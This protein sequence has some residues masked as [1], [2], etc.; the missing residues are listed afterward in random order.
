MNDQPDQ[1]PE[2]ILPALLR[3]G[4]G[5]LTIGWDLAVP[6]VGGVLLGHFLDQWLG[7][8]YTFTLG[9]LVL[10]VMIAYFNLSRLIRRLDQQDQQRKREKQEKQE[11]QERQERQEEDGG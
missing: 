3:E 7:T 5:V 9:L 11:R 8:G 2:K 4:M 6:I 1:R 10:G